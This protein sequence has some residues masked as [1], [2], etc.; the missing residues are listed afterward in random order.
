M[1]DTSGVIGMAK[2]T[3]KDTA[4]STIQTVLIQNPYIDSDV[5][6][7]KVVG[8]GCGTKNLNLIDSSRITLG[9]Q[10]I[11]TDSVASYEVRF[12]E[13][14]ASVVS[15]VKTYTISNP[16]TRNTLY[17]L[18]FLNKTGG[19]DSYTFNRA[20]TKRV[21]INRS[22]YKKNA[23]SLT[24]SDSYGY[25]ARA[26]TNIAYNTTQKDNISVLSDWITEEESTWLEELISSPEVYL[27][28][29]TYGLVSINVSNSSYDFK[30]VATE[31]LFNLRISFTYSYDRFRQ[32]Y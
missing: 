12:A 22:S 27:E 9:A 16:C 15:L 20:D 24:A 3:T 5:F 1:T 17:R 8:F 30:Q 21:S 29:A 18:H 2:V 4:G 26:R 10:P 13:L 14:D 6:D 32:R 23:A 28:D 31:K 25:T 7:S 19:F 11:I